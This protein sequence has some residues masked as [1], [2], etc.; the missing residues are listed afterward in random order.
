MKL[1]NDNHVQFTKLSNSR[2][3]ENLQQRKKQ[4]KK[5]E[6][7]TIEIIVPPTISLSCK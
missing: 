5:T 7:E 3:E 6:A 2:F 4:T 1:Q